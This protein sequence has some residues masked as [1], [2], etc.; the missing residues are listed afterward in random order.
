MTLLA[1]CTGGSGAPQ[2]VDAGPPPPPPEVTVLI[3]G[4]EGGWILSTGEAGKEK[5]GAAETMARWTTLEHHADDALGADGEPA[6]PTDGTLALSTGDHGPGPAISAAFLG[7][8]MAEVMRQM[9]YAA[10]AF[11][12]H[13]LGFGREQFFKNRESA[14]FPYLAA[15][16]KVKSDAAKGLELPPFKLF[17]RR[18]FAIAAVGLVSTGAPTTTM[19]GR[20]DGLEVQGYA[21]ALAKAVPAAWEAGADAVV[22]LA[23]ACPADLQPILEKH[24]DWKVTLAAG[25]HCGEHTDAKAGET[26]IVYPGRHFEHYVS[27]KLTF[28]PT[29]PAKERLSKVEV[30]HVDVV[31]GKD[32]PNP[33]A[34]LAIYIDG[35]KKKLDNQLGEKIGYTKSGLT[36][37]SPMLDKWVTTAWREVLKT[38]MAVA[39]R[40]GIREGIGSGDITRASVYSMLPFENS[41]IICKIKGADLVKELANKNAVFSGSKAGTK[42]KDAKGKPIDPKKVYS[43][44]MADYIYFGG[45]G[46][47]FEKKD[48]HGLETGMTWQTPVI[49]WTK[50]EK[51]GPKDPLEKKLK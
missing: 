37:D 42:F 32:A 16:L 44:A 8:P 26:P 1:G 15:N 21:D 5:G 3:T 47:N 19:P 9:G 13:E 18:G 29:K 25:G 14:G 22:I 20:F 49:E 45:D 48:P 2:P 51:L 24:A 50:R 31:A 4:D 23:D 10:S 33:N 40:G 39:N 38:D 12:R 35:W 27:A 6:M 43:V 28:D 7:K 46:F 41:V 17:K 36:D 34:S 11:G 30:K